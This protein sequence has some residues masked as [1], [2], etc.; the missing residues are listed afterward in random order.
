VQGR[1]AEFEKISGTD[2][3][4]LNAFEREVYRKLMTGDFGGPGNLD[5]RLRARQLA[6]RLKL[7]KLL[8]ILFVILIAFLYG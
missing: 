5:L 6:S 1:V 8:C 2:E 3:N 4:N 7:L